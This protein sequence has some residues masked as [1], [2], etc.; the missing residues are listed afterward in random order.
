[1][2]RRRKLL[3][4]S[5]VLSALLLAAL[6]LAPSSTAAPPPTGMS[7]QEVDA[8]AQTGV[9]YVSMHWEGFVNV[10]ASASANGTAYWSDR[11]KADATCT[12][13]VVSS[14]GYIVTAGHCADPVEGKHALVE[15][16]LAQEVT[17]GAIQQATM[18]DMIGNGGALDWQVEG[19]ADGSQPEF[20]IAAYMPA[21][22]SGLATGQ[23]LTAAVIDNRPL[24][25]GDVTVLKVQPQ[26][27][28]S[29]LQVSATEP[30]NGD[31]VTA[32]GYPGN[33]DKVVDPTNDPS[34]K[35]GHVSSLNTS[36][37][38]PFIQTDAALSPGMSGGPVVDDQGQVVGLNSY[39]IVGETQQFNFAADRTTIQA[40]LRRNGVNNTLSPADQAYRAGLALYY[41]G[42]YHAAVKQ[43][44]ITLATVPSHAQAQKFRADAVAKYPLDKTSSGMPLWVWIAIGV[45]AVVLIGGLVW[46]LLARRR[47]DKGG[48]TL[49]G[50][51]LPQPGSTTPLP[52]LSQDGYPV[53]S[54]PGYTASPNYTPQANVG[55]VMPTITDVTCPVCGTR[56]AQGTRV[57]AKE[58]A[59]LPASTV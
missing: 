35:S 54:D 32:I 24:S 4:G 13:F 9:V 44:D 37:G 50:P 47:N 8:I 17:K 20:T 3:S 40:A 1:M 39:K 2:D 57:C 10:P 53:S 55:V 27:P 59:V 25:Q 52:H 19:K 33:V 38:A 51:P 6:A 22:V 56:Y 18:D 15:T 21:S 29:V 36:N 7:E 58:G 49:Q 41:Q 45:G 48:R 28:L 23:K 42:K 14:D 26:T 46:W 16:Y 11:V 31:A 43:F 34:F 5:G 12:G 30:V